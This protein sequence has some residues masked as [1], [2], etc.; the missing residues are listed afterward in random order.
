[1][2]KAAINTRQ[3]NTEKRNNK[4]KAA[5]YTRYTTQP[6]PRL[7]SREYVISQLAEEHNLSMGTIENILYKLKP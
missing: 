6:R 4:I 5:F 3:A 1:M 7:Y 2:T